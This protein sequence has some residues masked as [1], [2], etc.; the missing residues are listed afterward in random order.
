MKLEETKFLVH[1]AGTKLLLSE[2][3]IRTISLTS[4]FLDLCFGRLLE[5]ARQ[6][7]PADNLQDAT[8]ILA[9]RTEA[10]REVATIVR[11]GP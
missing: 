5:A 10:S 9:E 11:E 3:C 1:V 4:L 7:N 2:V 6:I 8:R